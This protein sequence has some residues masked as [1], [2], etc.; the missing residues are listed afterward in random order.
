MG[1]AE[2]LFVVSAVGQPAQT[3]EQRASTP[4]APAP[5]AAPAPAPEAAVASSAPPSSGT[6]SP[7]ASSDAKPDAATI[8]STPAPAPTP[9]P[10]VPQPIDSAPSPKSQ[11]PVY[12]ESSR[13]LGMLIAGPLTV[14]VGLPVS[15]LGNLAWRQACGPDTPASTCARGSALSGF[16]HVTTSLAYAGGITLTGLGAGRWGEYDA[17]RELAGERPL[18]MRTGLKVAGAIVLP[19]AVLGMGLARLL[20]W[21]PTPDCQTEGCVRDY[22]TASTLT[23]GGLGLV[24]ALGAG[25]LMYGVKH[26]RRIKREVRISFS[27]RGTAHFSGFVASGYF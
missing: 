25:M 11:P 10:D 23:V 22:Q 6:V 12:V 7:P 19:A 14:A 20:F 15:L 17:G 16:A 2:C 27:P 4:E 24:G 18:R 26:D 3:D 9:G 5:A 8:E 21:L 13:G 1:W